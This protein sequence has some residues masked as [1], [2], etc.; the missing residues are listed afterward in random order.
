MPRVPLPEP[1]PETPDVSRGEGAAELALDLYRQLAEAR[2]DARAAV[3]KA[4]QR[5]ESHVL[6]TSATIAALAAERFELDRL[7]KRI[8]PELTARG[9]ADVI[10]VLD[11][12][13]RA[14]SAALA[15]EGI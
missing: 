9:A 10:R 14:W 3:E 5:I 7:L 11:L 2:R 6:S 1:L 8:E 15:R 13:A 4:D 12:F